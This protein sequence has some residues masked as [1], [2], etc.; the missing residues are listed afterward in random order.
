[1]GRWVRQ[2]SVG[3]M[4][5]TSLLVDPIPGAHQCHLKSVAMGAGLIMLDSCV[6]LTGE[7][8]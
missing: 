7:G 2:P 8:M 1:M 4:L 3:A 5:G 6:A